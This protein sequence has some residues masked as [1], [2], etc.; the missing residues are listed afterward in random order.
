[1]SSVAREV[2]PLFASMRRMLQDPFLMTTEPFAFPE[3]IGWFPPVEVTESEGE[4]RLTA[5]LP[6]LDRADVKIE[7]DGDVLTL[8]G[9]KREER[10]EEDTGKRYHLE[11][12]RYGAFYRAFTLPP[13]VDAE[14]ISAEFDRGV[15][16]LHL[17]KAAEAMPRG[18][19]IPVGTA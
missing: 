2:D 7:L 5:E 19:E 8:R 15:L 18:R 4:L 10:K 6:G 13:A 17:P 16:T 12:R 3:P 11:E 1:M 9:E 14:K